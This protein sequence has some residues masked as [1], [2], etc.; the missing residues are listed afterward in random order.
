MDTEYTVYAPLTDFVWDGEDFLR[1]PKLEIRKNRHSFNLR[2]NEDCLSDFQRDKLFYADHWLT[3][4]WDDESEPSA[5]ETVNLFLLSLWLVKPTK[6]NVQLRFHVNQDSASDQV[7]M[8]WI[9][10][11]VFSWV[12]ESVSDSFTSGDL[13]SAASYFERVRSIHLARRRLHHA[14]FLTYAGCVATNWAVAFICFT[15]AAEALLTHS[16]KPGLTKR[17]AVAFA[18][19]TQINQPDRDRA[20]LEFRDLYN[21]RS[22]IIHGRLYLRSDLDR[23]GTLARFQEALRDVW[24]AILP[25]HYA[26]LEGCDDQRREFFEKLQ[27]S[28]QPPS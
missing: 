7:G 11:E 24:R 17:L 20:Y 2:G 5:A 18:C 27:S 12:P 22:D 16:R 10:K 6:A 19:L 9:M 21:V 23:L 15:S 13:E 3:F 28:Y 4:E 25:G 26:S 8:T 1:F 14:I